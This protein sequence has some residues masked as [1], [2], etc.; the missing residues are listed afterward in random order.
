MCYC[1]SPETGSVHIGVARGIAATMDQSSSSTRSAEGTVQ[2]T[3]GGVSHRSPDGCQCTLSYP[4]GAG[5]S[6]EWGYRSSCPV[7]LR[8]HPLFRI[9]FGIAYDM[10]CQFAGA[11]N[12]G[13][14][15][16][17]DRK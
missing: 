11:T 12:Y 8:E 13:V 16:F 14:V 3:T 6:F 17:L 9:E 4:N 10:D 7:K 2:T 5:A 15:T 1:P